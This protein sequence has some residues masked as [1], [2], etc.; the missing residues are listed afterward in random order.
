[1]RLGN[2]ILNCVGNFLNF[3]FTFDVLAIE[4]SFVEI[5]LDVY[6]IPEHLQRFWNAALSCDLILR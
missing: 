3:P 2:C 1:M 6:L 4:H 5:S